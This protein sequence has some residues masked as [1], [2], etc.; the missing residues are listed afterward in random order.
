MGKETEVTFL[1]WSSI[2]SPV[3]GGLPERFS[4]RLLTIRKEVLGEA[5]KQRR[6]SPRGDLFGCGC[7]SKDV[8]ELSPYSSCDSA[9]T[10][11]GAL[12][13]PVQMMRHINLWKDSLLEFSQTGSSNS[14][15]SQF[16][17]NF[18]SVL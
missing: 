18:K 2:S 10:L 5:A 9:H 11:K 16:C 7:D 14:L 3:Q 1:H 6:F 15:K 13:T 8:Y 17:T 4:S 12:S